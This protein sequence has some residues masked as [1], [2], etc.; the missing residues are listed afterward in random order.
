[1]H[2]P[3]PDCGRAW[4]VPCSARPENRTGKVTF[5]TWVPRLGRAPEG[6]TARALLPG[7]GVLL[8]KVS[9]LS[10]RPISIAKLRALLRFHR[11]P[12]YL[13]VYKGSYLLAQ[14]ESSS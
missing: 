2:A 6:A 10:P 13:I 1:M 14:W 4:A 7:M 12:I 8:A 5:E 11:R 9:R 3:L